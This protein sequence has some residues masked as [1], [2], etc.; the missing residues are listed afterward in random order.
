VAKLFK[1]KR[2]KEEGEEPTPK[3]KAMTFMQGQNIG[4]KMIMMHA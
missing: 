2:S 1:R 3:T 4:E